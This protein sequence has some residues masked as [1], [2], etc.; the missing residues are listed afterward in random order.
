MAEP[1]VDLRK[2]IA[3][4]AARRGVLELVTVPPLRY[5]MLDGH[6]DPNTAPAYRDT[7]ATLYPLAYAVKFLSKRELG[8]DYA[9]PPLEGLW[10]ADDMA[11]FTAARDKAQWDWTM[12]LLVP[13]WVG[14]DHVEAARA[15]V[16]AKGGAPLLDDVRLG[17]LDEG[18]CVQTLHVGSYDDEGPVLDELHRRFLPEHGLRP[19]GTHHEVYLTDARRTA[20]ERLRT[21]LRQPVAPV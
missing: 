7:L 1:K 3:S 14:E 2:A 4:Y 10:W 11:A 15:T 6:G 17:T 20:P 19:A 9:V 18:L 8:R 16:A 5:L 12:L 21:I 13:D